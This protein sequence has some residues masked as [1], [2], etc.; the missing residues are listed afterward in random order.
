MI[1]H[2]IQ[3]LRVVG[4][5]LTMSS[6]IPASD[7]LF[8]VG[9]SKINVTPTVDLR[10][11]GYGS[12]SEV[13]TGV[14][15]QIFVRAMALGRGDELCV[16][17]SIE[18]IGVIPRQ[19]ERLISALQQ[20]YSI[21]RAR[22]V[23]CSTHSHTAPHLHGGLTNLFRSPTTVEQE[24]DLKEYM[25]VVHE[26]TLA[27]IE[28]AI[29]A[30]IP[31][32]LSIG[33]AEASFATHRRVLKDG[34][35]TGFGVAPDGPT[36]RRVQ[37]LVARD[38]ED[39][40]CGA[41]FQYACHCTTLGPK[42]NEVTGDWA[43]IAAAR[44]EGN[45][46]EAVFLPV[47]G[48]GA[49]ANPEPRGEYEHAVAHG[50]EMADAVMSVLR[51]DTLASLADLPSARFGYAGLSAELPS[52]EAL[53]EWLDDSNVNRQRWA[54]SMLEVWKAKGR[55]PESY[56]APIHTWRF[57][58]D[59]VWVFLGGE[60]VVQYQ[61]RLEEALA[62]FSNVWVAAYADDV[63]AYVAAEDMR[64][65]GG[66]EVDFSMVYY[67]QPGRWQS[68]TE[69]LLVRR[70]KEVL[71]SPVRDEG[72][73]SPQESLECFHL[74]DGLEIEL[75]VSEP[76]VTDPVNLAF[77]PDGSVWVVEMG[78]YPLSKNG[79]RVRRLS[80]SDRNGTF[81]EA[82]VFLEG[83]EF[84]TSVLPWRD[85]AIV[86]AA[87]DIFFARDTDGDGKAD[88]REVLLTGVGHANP[89]HRASGFEWGLDGW[90]YF[91][92]GDDT[93]TLISHRAGIRLDVSHSD[94]RWKP[95]TGEIERLSGATQFVR[96][97]DRWG[98][99]FGN[100][101]SAPIFQYTLDRP[102]WLS[103]NTG[104]RKKRLVLNPGIAPP[105]FP[106]SRT[107]DRFNDLF[108]KNRFT[109]VCSSIFLK[110]P[111]MGGQMQDAALVCEPVHNLIARFRSSKMV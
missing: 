81:N 14:R 55:L 48:C 40:L 61:M 79:G 100:T 59:L 11:S 32:R 72:P 78:D 1:T 10:L 2:W 35:W 3:A 105:V 87:P 85:G 106:K 29:E 43:G 75:V 76:L 52:R 56:P 91:G 34:V 26:K 93:E 95:D 39:R 109:S 8:E 22:L 80:D 44:L 108:A 41:V 25:D 27:C 84:P 9:F 104:F 46:E 64:S 83:L 49:D 23:L 53:T 88:E 73:K 58:D 111:G 17:V 19:S 45:S 15:D 36:D 6:A 62:E 24:Q 107:V 110:S 92:A 67:N 63:F 37:V 89:Q 16:L 47:I 54:K 33:T 99:W 98:R 18:G 30:Q 12:R 94:V 69:D 68:G 82:V 28:N 71:R 21:D 103:R 4:V 60:V 101:N 50:V 5:V 7:G 31:C 38:E 65:A 66:Y 70:A 20:K 77:A 86:I 13:M 97:R 51:S 42:F 57:G 74:P 90:V 96:S 102:D